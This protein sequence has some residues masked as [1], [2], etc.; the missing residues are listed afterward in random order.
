R[1]AGRTS[2]ST[3]PSARSSRTG[4]TSAGTSVARG[5]SGST[6]SMA[7][8]SSVF[9]PHSR[10][11]PLQQDLLLGFFAHPSPFFLTG[12]AALVGFHFGHRTT[13]DL[14]FFALPGAD[15]EAGA[16]IVGAVA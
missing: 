7:G 3:S 9:S 2:G 8:A 13:E 11:T 6:S 12:G 4:T 16:R 14:D 5:T 1:P 10:L 15:L